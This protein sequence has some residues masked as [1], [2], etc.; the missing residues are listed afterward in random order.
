MRREAEK[1]GR[2][3]CVMDVEG[4]CESFDIYFDDLPVLTDNERSIIVEG[5]NAF[6]AVQSSSK[7]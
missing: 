6:S 2:K 5:S 3:I 1:V 4:Q 7:E